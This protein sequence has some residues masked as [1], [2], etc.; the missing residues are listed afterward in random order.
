M[1]RE[2]MQLAHRYNRKKHSVAGYFLSE[3]RDGMRA[4]WDGGI[5]RGMFKA[6]VPWANNDKDDRYNV[7]PIATGLW[8]RYGNVIHAPDWWLDRLPN[9]P[10]DGELYNADYRQTL[11]SIVKKIFSTEEWKHV[12]YHVFDIPNL[13]RM[14]ADGNI[15]GTNFTR[16]LCGIPQWLDEHPQNEKGVGYRDHSF[17]GVQAIFERED[18]DSRT[19]IIEP[20]QE[21]PYNRQAADHIVWSKLTA[22]T[23]NGG[24]GVILRNPINVWMPERVHGMLKVKPDNDAEGKVVGYVS[25]RKTDKGSKLL[26]LM[27]ALI[28]EIKP[29]PDLK[30]LELSGFTDEERVLSTIEDIHSSNDASQW[31]RDNPGERCPN[32]IISKHFPIGTTIT[33]KFRGKSKDGIPQEARYDRI[34]QED[35][36]V[37]GNN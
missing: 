5:T 20:Q 37:T 33:F 8:S 19:V 2:F 9:F 13:Y 15:K 23:L 27:G 35:R 12:N 31:C 17:Q 10:L 4:F 1:K 22:I 28:L 34:R 30:V 32:W 6:D 36:T 16:E 18:L 21:L 25:G 3:K 29:R 14:M 11:M 7:P 24:E 26:G